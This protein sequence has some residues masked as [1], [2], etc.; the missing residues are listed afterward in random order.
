MTY[1]AELSYLGALEWFDPGAFVGDGETPQSV[2]DFILALSLAY[3]DFHDV[4]FARYLLAGV[5]PK[6]TETPSVPAAMFGGLLITLIRFQTGVIHELLKLV[7]ESEKV[8]EHAA[9]RKL[10][11]QLPKPAKDAWLAIVAAASGA[12]AAEAMTRALLFY[13]NKVAFHYDPKEIRRGYQ[14]R[15]GPESKNN[16]QP[17]LSRGAYIRNRRFFFADAAAEAYLASHGADPDVDA[18][19]RGK[20]PFIDAVNSALYELVTRFV[21]AR[22]FG[23]RAWRA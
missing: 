11:A 18:F 6:D 23:W 5:G 12:P 9:F 7:E 19:L 14:L 21:N 13:R 22:G 4:L 20:G 17:L 16:P 10:V 15:F 1:N 8:L 2:C 3:N